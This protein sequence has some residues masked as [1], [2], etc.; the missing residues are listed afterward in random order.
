MGE[1]TEVT[2]VDISKAVSELGIRQGDIAL[3]HSSLKSM[4]Y[5]RGGPA[6]V[7]KGFEDVLG[8]NGTL[9]LPTLSQV[10][11]RNSYKTWY[12]DKPSDTGYITEFFRKQPYVYRSNQATHSVAAR[13]KRAYE[14]T[15]EHTAYGPHICPFGEYA[16]AESSPWMKMYNNG[17]RIVFIG[18]SMEYNTMKH[19]VEARYVEDLLSKVKDPCRQEL[20]RAKL[21][22]FGKENGGVWLY[23]D[24]IKM[25][26]ALE[27]RGQTTR[28]NCGNAVFLSVC[29]KESSDTAFMLISEN[30]EDWYNGKELEWIQECQAAL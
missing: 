5:V 13:G 25:Q 11:F 18:V 4:G 20:L 22:S 1:I 21:A 2:A 19:M 27:S 16:F 6:A 15:C 14:L 10:D 7:I 8:K 17:A 3:V 29:A 23:Y 9:V 26:E 28:A 24:G 12:M 30:P